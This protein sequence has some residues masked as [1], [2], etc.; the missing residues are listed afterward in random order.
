[1]K[2]GIMQPYF[3]PYIG[4]WQLMNAVDEYVVY[5]DVNY[6]KG[7][8]INRNYLLLHGKPHLFTLPLLSASS[9]ARICEISMAPIPDKLFKTIEQAYGKAPYYGPTCDLLKKIFRFPSNN[10]SQFLFNSIQT[11]ASFLGMK[12]KFHLASSMDI[13]HEV[14][15][16]E[17]VLLICSM[18]HA[19]E[20]YNAIGGQELYSR[21][22]FCQADIRLRFLQP[23]P[24]EYPQSSGPF[25]PNLSILDVLMFNPVENVKHMLLKYV[26]V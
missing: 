7:G 11:V 12:T 21:E 22:V 20:Y 5:D 26:L 23:N 6:I 4:Y 3:L 8:W 10:L 18:L 17:R 15:A 13:S 25:I 19:S 2:L 9:F 16:Q 14:H 1:M 24:I